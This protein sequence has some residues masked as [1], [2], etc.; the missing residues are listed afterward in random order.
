VVSRAAQYPPP[1]IVGTLGA[2]GAAE[3][4]ALESMVMVPVGVAMEL[5][6]FLQKYGM[7]VPFGAL[8]GMVNVVVPENSPVSKLT[9]LTDPGANARGRASL[10]T[11][12]T[13]PSWLTTVTVPPGG[14]CRLSGEKAMPEMVMKKPVPEGVCW[15]GAAAGL[16]VLELPP[17]AIAAP[18]SAAST[19]F[20]NPLIFPS[21][22]FEA[23]TWRTQFPMPRFP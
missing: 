8:M 14:T 22:A 19:D 9:P 20:G 12:W 17:Q 15:G 1:P 4:V 23:V 16:K 5:V 10:V 3:A 18:A 13:T 11:E 21:R 2:A 7:A 6:W